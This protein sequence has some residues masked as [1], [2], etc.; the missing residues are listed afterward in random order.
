MRRRPDRLVVMQDL[1]MTQR[2]T[3]CT[4]NDTTF[5]FLLSYTV[6]A[7]C[8]PLHFTV[9]KSIR[10]SKLSSMKLRFVPSWVQPEI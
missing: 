10:I 6:I 2:T 8:F 9:R 5:V 4:P 1:R 7:T 3:I